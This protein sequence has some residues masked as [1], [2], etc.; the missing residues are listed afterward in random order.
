MATRD[1]DSILGLV[2]KGDK[3]DKPLFPEVDDPG[4]DSRF[5]FRLPE[6][7]E[8]KIRVHA[9]E[10]RGG[11]NYELH[12]QRFVAAPLELG[13]PQV[14]AFDREGKDYL[15]FQ[16]IKDRVLTTQ[17]KGSVLDSWKML[18]H[19]G[20]E[21]AGWADARTIEESGECCLVVA[22]RPDM[23]YEL[24]VREAHCADLGI[25]KGLAANLP[26]GEMD[27]WG[28]SAKPGDFRLLEI[29]K[30]GEL[31]TRLIYAPLEK[32]NEQ[33]LARGDEWPEINALPVAS[34]GNHLRFADVLGR[35]GRYQLQVF[36]L[37][38]ASY[39]LK[40][41]D[42]TLAIKPDG[43]VDAGLP[44]GGT[45]F[46]G[47]KAMAG[48]LFHA[49]LG[50]RQFVPLLRLYD[51]RGNLQATSDTNSDEL[52]GRI[53]HMTMRAGL[54][55]LQVSS[56]GDGGGG[57]FRLAVRETKLRE[58]AVG[59]RGQG[60]LQ[61]SVTDFWAFNGKAGQV[62]FVSV[63]SPGCEPQAIVRS[64]DGVDLAA[65]DHGGEGTGSLLAL[66]LPTT[67]RY[68][69][70]ISSRRGAGPYTLRLID[71]D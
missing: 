58:L 67:G 38:A 20:R 30:K 51:V 56:Q 63:R 14:G 59:G 57:D 35:T 5:S 22:G 6:K 7:G 41:A 53:T 25:G 18:D 16:G 61:P 60:T 65:N 10:Y 36:A 66:K 1:F 68:T 40:M 8:Y 2:V 12:L 21:M 23:R 13:K 19:K 50:S 32:K 49:E 42:P 9:F 71:A 39:T 24:L 29:E 70:W 28:F 4:S 31:A 47:F 34:R 69:I 43:E 45:G 54:Y 46:F 62:V 37:T 48:E 15:Y 52:Q 17:I 44:V 3:A 33:R 64:P 27:V 26:Q 11:G 55:R